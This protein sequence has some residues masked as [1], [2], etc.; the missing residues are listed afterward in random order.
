MTSTD[1]VTWTRR[2]SGTVSGLSSVAYGNGKFVA[3][4]NKT[5]DGFS[6]SN[7]ELTSANG[8]TWTQQITATADHGIAYGNG[9]FVGLTDGNYIIKSTDGM[10]WTPILTTDP[11][12]NSPVADLTLYDVI[13][14]NSQF[15]QANFHCFASREAESQTLANMR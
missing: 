14:A 13:F 6:L 7:V 4:G 15:V 8:T 12:L 10:N 3:V 9:V 1:G 11:D 5:T 2:S